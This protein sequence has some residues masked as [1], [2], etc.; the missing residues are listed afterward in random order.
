[1][2][3]NRSAARIGLGAVACF[4]GVALVVALRAVLPGTALALVGIALLV[5]GALDRRP[6]RAW[7]AEDGLDEDES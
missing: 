5:T 1:M 7:L 6:V 2:D 4:L 3:D